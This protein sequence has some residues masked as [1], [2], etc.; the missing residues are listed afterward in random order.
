MPMTRRRRWMVRLAQSI[1]VGVL[2]SLL[3]GL[4]GPI[5]P[6]RAQTTQPAAPPAAP[7]PPP[8]PSGPAAP[9]SVDVASY[10][11]D[12]RWDAATSQIHGSATIT[13]RNHSADTL[14]EV[15]LKLYL[16]AFRHEETQWMRESGGEHRGSGYDPRRPG[17][18]RLEGL[19]LLDTGEDLLP[20][21]VDPE[22]TVLRIPL[23]AA[24]A[25]GPGETT[26]FA[27]TWTSQLPRVF[28]RTG[29][30]DD[31]VMAGQWY[32][33]LA[34]YDRGAWDAE[35]WHANAEFFAD[36]GSYTLTLTVPA[37]YVTGATGTRDSTV[38]N[39]DGTT[40]VRYWAESVSDVAWTAWPGYRTVT[41]V[42]EAAGRPVELELLAPRAM[43]MDVD[44][45]FFTSAQ[46]ALDLLGRWFGPYPWPRLT[47]VVPPPN[48]AG[49]GGMEYPML[50]TLGQPIPA[51]GLERGLLGAE[52]VTVHEIA[53]QWVPL[54]LAT[55]EAREAW[56]D[57]GFADYATMRVLGSV[58]GRDR[59]LLD[60][61]P[62]KMGYEEV[63][64]IQYLFAGVQQRLAQP[65]W[66]YPDLLTYGATVYSKGSLALLTL[67]R[68]Y[69]EERFLAALGAHFDRW[70]WRHPT[71]ADL[72]QSLEGGLDTSLD[73]FFRPMVYGTSV[74]EY[75][76]AEAGEQRAIVERQGD[77]AIP[78][79]VALSYVDGS[80][81]S[82]LWSGDTA[83][84]VVQAPRAP[85]ARIQVDPGQ[86]IRLEPNVL[87]NGREV[88]PSP[89]P[90]LTLAARLLGLIQAALL[91]GMVG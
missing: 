85:L 69:G 57:E 91:A 70:R 8:A 84:I 31:F 23:P 41:R 77:A 25:I 83:R 51:F 34:V 64:R 9:A 15:W 68:A 75:R 33:K 43:S 81:D 72:Q 73:W 71:T 17:W 5:A 18:I 35:P 32:P 65:S 55:N 27:V 10:D 19:Q 89:L 36:F 44:A 58:Y 16:N 46:Q 24:R 1:V 82:A 2:L 79:P 40:T 47:L 60:I 74:V 86:A 20:A 78:V 13:Y 14:G 87:D 12:A 28:A 4:V 49:A 53:H 39:A 76:V 67:E 6:S 30:A 3:A 52:V 7:P 62:F 66:L 88:A 54:Q 45:R 50:V 22:A 11:L 48:A 37:G 56:L 26:R 80:G 63:Q 61:G 21:D 29:V 59:S 38:A 90:L 42:V